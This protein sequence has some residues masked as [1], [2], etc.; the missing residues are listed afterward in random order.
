MAV[1]THNLASQTYEKILKD[2]VELRLAPGSFLLERDISEQL[3]VSRTP[4]REAIKR[5][6]QEGWL[7]AQERRRPVVKGISLEEGEAIFQFRN[8]AEV[9]AL[10]WTVDNG[11]ARS[12]AGLLDQEIQKM[13]LLRD[14]PI[15]FLRADVQFHST[16]I[17]Q[18]NN[19]YLSRAWHTVGEEIVRY[20]LYSMDYTRT[21][22][23]INNEHEALVQSLWENRKEET[24]QTLLTHHNKVMAGLKR[25]LLQFQTQQM[26]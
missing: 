13:L 9:F 4:V 24:V 15:L 7:I 6:T 23:T 25:Q 21:V 26:E 19:K 11:M 10:E 1:N 16:I 20:A 12:L 8:M 17:N 18:V 22:D 14:Q 3:G 2:I 5:L